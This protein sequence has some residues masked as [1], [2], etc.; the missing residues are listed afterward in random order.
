M[1]FF[2]KIKNTFKNIKR[3]NK[4]VAFVDQHEKDI[5]V[6]LNGFRGIIPILQELKAQ[7]DTEKTL[8]EEGGQA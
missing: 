1:K 4:I 6:I 5:E 3:Y 2:K 8:P 7:L